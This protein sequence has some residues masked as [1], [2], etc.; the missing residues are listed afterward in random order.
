[1]A[2]EV[3]IETSPR[4]NN[5]EPVEIKFEIIN[6][7]AEDI[8]VLKWQT[9]LEGLKSDCLKVMVNGHR[10]KYDGKL[11]KRR[12]PRKQ[13]Y[14]LI[15]AGES[16]SKTIDL[17]VAYNVSEQGEY[18]VTFDERKLVILPPEGGA[19]LEGLSDL[20]PET[21]TLEVIPQP[22]NFY[23]EAGAEPRQT[24]GQRMRAELEKKM[25]LNDLVLEAAI[26]Q[27][28]DIGFVG[29]TGGQK[30]A[31]RAAHENAYNYV[32]AGLE[33]LNNNENYKE[34]FGNHTAIREEKVRKRLLAVKNAMESKTFVYDLSGDA[35][36]A[37][38]DFAFTFFGVSAIWFCS[39]FWDAPARG[40]ASKAGTI[41]HEH[42]HSSAEVEDIRDMYGVEACRKLA[43]EK[44]DDALNNAD[45]Y[46]FFVESIE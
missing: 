40:I 27:L 31:V 12:E 11:V 13:D 26:P 15:K 37:D 4:H 14:V 19:G 8:Y 2:V 46:E 38:G 18:E 10:V 44:P 7:T 24:I 33:Q 35:E 41:V 20:A 6:D 17:S 22:T 32:K 28:Q 1:M 39:L 45:N 3:R 16:L 5:D 29:G 9:P 42:T 36:C 21:T 25:E 34:W 23:I 43:I 30:N